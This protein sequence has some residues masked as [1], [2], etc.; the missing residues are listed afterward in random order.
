MADDVFTGPPQAP[1]F[2]SGVS[3]ADS[4]SKENLDPPHPTDRAPES[5]NVAA[6]ISR[7]LQPPPGP[8]AAAPGIPSTQ[9]FPSLP[10]PSKPQTTAPIAPASKKTTVKPTVT[11]AKPVIQRKF[12][13]SS[14][15]HQSTEKDEELITATTKE[16]EHGQDEEQASSGPATKIL[17]LKPSAKDVAS[18]MTETKV[19]KSLDPLVKD[20][21][22][23]VQKESLTIGSSTENNA[24]I[25]TG[26]SSTENKSSAKAP[27]AAT[28]SA[29]ASEPPKKPKSLRL[30]AKALEKEMA[31]ISVTKE[32]ERATT[33]AANP[34]GTPSDTASF[35]TTTISRPT[36]PQ[37]GKVG[38]APVRVSKTQQKKERQ[39]RAKQAEAE[40]KADQQAPV[41]ITPEE[42]AIVQEPIVGRK[43]KAK[44]SKPASTAV[45]ST[46]AESTPAPSR[47]GSPDRKD[48]TLSKEISSEPMPPVA[49]EPGP[50]VDLPLS[51]SATPTPT[52]RTAP[53]SPKP[54]PD[55]PPRSASP[56][57][58]ELFASLL[59]THELP[60]SA[61]DL[62]NPIHPSLSTNLN[63][64]PD[65]L[66][67][68]YLPTLTQPQLQLLDSG[69]AILVE[70][71]KGRSVVVLPG[72]RLVQGLSRVQGER[73][74]Q[75]S[76]K[77]G[78]PPAP[79]ASSISGPGSMSMGGMERYLPP[80]IATTL[81]PFRG[82]AGNASAGMATT[83]TAPGGDA[84]AVVLADV[85]ADADT[86]SRDV[87][88]GSGELDNP[89]SY[90]LEYEDRAGAEDDDLVMY[91][92]GRGGSA[93]TAAAAGMI[94]GGGGGAVEGRAAASRR[95]AALGLDEAEKRY[96]ECRRETEAIEKR[97]NG[98]IKRNRRLILG[99][100]H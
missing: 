86:M 61:K 74:V 36:S 63:T 60:P 6:M 65:L 64:P 73:F 13:I 79:S 66:D 9:D 12:T 69:S 99:G 10:T 23:T 53:P 98:L 42:P 1:R 80:A 55:L 67:P 52:T 21:K 35:T 19:R 31:S 20:V 30:G 71:K 49:E 38:S 72:G 77:L 33:A 93:D 43:K 26:P 94:G 56:T 89:F 51:T 34:P 95:A 25:A 59:S 40:K 84:A 39:A 18:K 82:S 97:L 28:G 68:R 45:P 57:P 91:E 7:N 17:D 47:P 11:N 50:Q 92:L 70:D 76:N 96:A 58:A 88:G 90:P 87:S 54:S 3:K 2:P 100:G 15:P 14:D 85:A 44:K 81:P 46:T 75:L 78:I 24:K 41:A 83:K 5:S 22:Q 27:A 37:G 4:T 62:F 16:S 29:A 48:S 8:P 32:A